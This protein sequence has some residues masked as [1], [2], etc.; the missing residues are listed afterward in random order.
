VRFLWIGLLLILPVRLQAEPVELLPEKAKII[1]VGGGLS[2]IVHSIGAGEQM[3]GRDT[4]STYPPEVQALPDVGYMRALSPEGV[5]SLEPQ[6][7]I[8]SEGSGPPQALELLQKLSLPM[9]MVAENY[10]RAGVLSKIATV[11]HALRR[12]AQAQALIKIVEQDFAKVDA[13]LSG[14]AEKKRVLFVLSLQ[15]GRIMAAG[16]DTAADAMIK[17]AGG[18][19]AVNGFSGYKPI[20]DEALISSAPDLIL[21]MTGGGGH[22]VAAQLLEIPAVQ[23]TPAA[24][25]NKI[26]QMDGLFLLGFG[27][28]VGQAAYELALLLYGTV[29]EAASTKS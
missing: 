28:R 1:V 6:G 29:D 9:V 13:L 15:N 16:S 25:H 18:V 14:I 4:T 22:D 12:E 19:N 24:R 17:L 11:G 10:S 3:I 21:S 26:H 7:L 2:E 23:E 8:L 5:L 20:N 27:P